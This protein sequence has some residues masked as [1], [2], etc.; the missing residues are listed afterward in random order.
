MNQKKFTATIYLYQEK[1]I[2]SLG[3][4]EVIAANPVE[5]AKNYSDNNADEILLF[6]LSRTDEEHEKAIGLMKRIVEECEVPVIAAGNIKRFEDVKKI[7]YAGCQK[8]VLNYSK[9]SNIAITE[10]VSKRF[11][12]DKIMAA[13]TKAEQISQNR[14]LLN[15][16]VSELLLMQ[17]GSLS[18]CIKQSELSM[19]VPVADIPL[20]R[21]LDI[22]EKTEISGV[23]GTI[24]NSNINEINGMKALCKERGIKT[25]GFDAA[26]SW[27]ELTPNQDG[28]IPVVVQDYKTKEV[29]MV[30]YMNEQAFETTIQTGRMTYYSR[31]RKSQ[32][33]K[34]ETSGHFQYVKSLT[35][36]CDSDTILA[37][38]SQI[39]VACHTGS[40]SC[41]FKEIVKRECIETD[42]LKVFEDV[43]KVILDRKENPKEGSYTNYLFDKG[44][45]KIL[46]K[47]GEEATEI[48]IAAKNPDPEEIKYEIS[49]FLYHMMVLMAEKEVGWEEITR[50]LARR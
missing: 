50:E 6:D 11:G 34:G 29:L 3:N 42:P 48:V 10:E 1:A 22:L 5:L 12:K 39:G 49:D 36:D 27:K 4:K 2:K 21:L 17:E 28:L 23:F 33:V 47:L 9:E 38:V 26:I 41:F 20:D 43:Y 32:W 40:R 16:Y 14:A 45:D 37:K 25:N 19:L 35:A 31:S 46:K 44:I 15:E 7:L 13:I 8:A 30:A 24:V 18:E